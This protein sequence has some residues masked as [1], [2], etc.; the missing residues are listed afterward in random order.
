M[1]TVVET[2]TRAFILVGEVKDD[3]AGRELMNAMGIR[4]YSF[5]HVNNSKELSKTYRTVHVYRHPKTS[6]N[7]HVL[8][9]MFDSEEES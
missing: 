9:F 3:S 4:D 1:L 8:R 7:G 2:D 6:G 5:K